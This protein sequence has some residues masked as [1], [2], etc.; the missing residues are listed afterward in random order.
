MIAV[1]LLALNVLAEECDTVCTMD[2]TPVC[3]GGSGATLQTFPN[4]CALDVYNC[5]HGTG[6]HYATFK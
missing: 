2:Y 3:G 1:T 4:A 6:D 5:Q